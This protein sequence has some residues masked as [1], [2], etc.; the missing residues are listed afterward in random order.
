[1]TPERIYKWGGAALLLGGAGF[2]INTVYGDTVYEGFRPS[3]SGDSLWRLIGLIGLVGGVLIVFGFTALYA[4]ML[5]KVGAMGFW[6]YVLSTASGMIFGTG[7]GVLFTVAVPL[8]S[9][10][11]QK[12]WDLASGAQPPRTIAILFLGATLLFVIG[13]AIWGWAANRAK[14]L[15]SWGSWGL[16]ASAILALVLTVV[17]FA[18]PTV[19]PL[20]ADL[21]YVLLF[22]TAIGLGYRLW[23][24]EQVASI[25]SRPVA[26]QPA[27]PHP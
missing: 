19:N 21:G 9:A 1:M 24:G 14:A 5:R 7:F 26:H 8:M 3:H 18:Q 17:R 4:S 6:G 20:L 15:P 27:S 13:F 2:L 11:D 10:D 23:A 16:I 22:V 12:T 25:S